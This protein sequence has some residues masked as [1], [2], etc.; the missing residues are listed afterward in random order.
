MNY[1]DTDD[2]IVA[3][4][5]ADGLGAVSII[6]ISGKQI[7]STYKL[8]S[9]KK[10]LPRKNSIYF[11]KIYS[12]TSQ[13]HVDDGLIA[14]FE[15]PSSFTGESV[16]EINCHG[17]NYVANN[18]IQDLVCSGLAR[19]ALPGE[20]SFRA[21]YNGKI[22]LVQAESINDLIGS[23]SNLYAQGALDNING[24]L[25]EKIDAIK[26]TV[27]DLLSLIEH[28]LD[29]N[30]DEIDFT[31][32]DQLIKLLLS[33]NQ[34]IKE[35]ESSFL[36]SKIIRNGI[37][38]LLLGK[39]NVGK[40]SLFNYL[41]G[42]HRALV[43]NI[44]GTTRDSLEAVYEIEGFR[45]TLIDSAGIIKSSDPLETLAIEKTKAEIEHAH[46]VVV[47]ANKVADL[48]KYDCLIKDKVSISLLSKSDL[49]NYKNASS[50][51]IKISSKNG[52]NIDVFLTELST[53][54]KSLVGTKNRNA[55]L[56]INSRHYEL[57]SKGRKQIKKTILLLK[58]NA[59]HDIVAESILCFLDMLNNIS[60]PVNRKEII[61]NIF[62]KFCIGK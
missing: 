22:D 35:I 58:E 24:K 14:Y 25:S 36:S 16:L 61:N 8:I 29:F 42:S 49:I 57:L 59:T 30:E 62:S 28:E 41:M 60:T 56:L 32:N 2:N 23:E 19:H 4:A 20:F 40:S 7:K 26:K 3:L 11:N 17:G 34:K 50:E 5:T 27:V 39:P 38:V 9:K 1:L 18:I 46:I 52:E 53:K 44:S 15:A 54:I 6:R 47:L 48:K 33:V 43:S 51:K 45:V 31:N 55:E 21:F 12:P 13:K 10:N 37:R